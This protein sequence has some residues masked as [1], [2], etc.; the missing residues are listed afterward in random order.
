LIPEQIAGMSF[1]REKNIW[2]RNKSPSKEHHPA[3]EISTT[4]ESEEDPFD[5]IPDLTVDETAEIM[6]KNQTSPSRPQPT[7]ETF[8]EETE[9][10]ANGQQDQSRPLTRDGKA[11]A[12]TDTS[13]V[14]SKFSNNFAW[15]F[16]KAE[17]RATSWS[18]QETRNGAS[19]KMQHA[20]TTTYPIPESDEIEVEHEI[21]YFEGRG[22]GATPFPNRTLRD[23]TF[24]IG[25]RRDQDSPNPQN[26]QPW[27]HANARHNSRSQGMS[28]RQKP[29]ART[30][31]SSRREP[32]Q[33]EG[34]VSSPGGLPARNYR[35]QLSMSVSAPVMGIQPQNALMAVPSSPAKA[36]VTFMLSD[37]PEFTLHQVDECELQDRVVVKHDGTRFSKALEDRYAQGTAD[38]IKAL[39]DVAPDEPYWEDLRKLDLRDKGLTNL[40]RLD[41][42]CY[43]LEELDVSNNHIS[44]LKGVPYTMRRLKMGNNVLTGL[45]SWASLMNLQHLDLSNNEVDSLDGLSELVHLRTLK[46]D[47]NHIKSL[48]GILLLDGLMELS[49]SGNQIEAVD[50]A[51]AD[52]YVSLPK[53]LRVN[54]TNV[55][56]GNH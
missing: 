33:E 7:A 11:T 36:D 43:R 46:V 34:D 45:T 53:L 24:S 17:T 55:D 10:N 9:E 26:Q 48:D 18:D 13:S 1:D 27:F 5:N 39:Q 22:A 30:L 51:K 12:P 49:A 52:L 37:L 8:L 2:V 16:P 14:P 29:G 32:Q 35:M 38:L 3:E 31:P 6:M 54:G 50:F 15:S 41:E 40:Y 25:Q 23:I 20:P 47:N 4:P 28:W 42:F 44:Q 56:L 19:Q 21:K